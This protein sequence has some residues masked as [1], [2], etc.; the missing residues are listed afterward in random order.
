MYRC[1]W[2][3]DWEY[4]K[5]SS[6]L[7]HMAFIQ[8]IPVEHMVDFVGQINSVRLQRDVTVVADITI[9]EPTTGL[10]YSNLGLIRLDQEQ[11]SN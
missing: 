4:G 1:R 10:A 7:K 8:E 2:A 11:G 9:G 6:G 3:R 5:L